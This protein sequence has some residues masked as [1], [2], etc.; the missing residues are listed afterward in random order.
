MARGKA[1][2]DYLHSPGLIGHSEAPDYGF[3]YEVSTIKHPKYNVGDVVEPG[4]GKG[5]VYCKS[6]G[7]CYTG[8]GNILNNAIP[9]T[10]IDYAVLADDSALGAKSVKMTCVVAIAEDELRGGQIV[11]KPASG[12]SDAVLQQ[13]GI[14][15][16]TAGA[17]GAVI[18]IYLDAPLTA[19]LTTSSYGFC[20]PS[21]YSSVRY[22]DT[23]GWDCSH[24]GIAAAYVD[25]ANGSTEIMLTGNV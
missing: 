5:F 12:S 15:G 20:M 23:G 2:T 22:N 13:R 10:G 9:A 11:L 19:A 6:S 4:N 16:N 1:K 7:I 8:R 18:T 14:V 25:A 21:P 3:L 24:V 17:I